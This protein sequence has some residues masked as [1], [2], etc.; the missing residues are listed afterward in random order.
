MTKGPM[1]ILRDRLGREDY[2]KLIRIDNPQL[3]Q[4]VARYVELCNPDEVFVCSDSPEDIQYIREEAIRT[5]EEKKLAVEGHTVHFDGYY[6]QARDKEN[7]RFLL[8]PSIDL[9]PHIKA[10]DKEKGLREIHTI[11]KNIMRGHRLY[12]CFFCLGPV[13]SEFTIPAVQLTDS[14]YVAHSEGLLYRP[15]YEEFRR[16]GNSARFFRFVHSQGELQGGVSKNVKQRRIYIDLENEAVYTANSQY[17][18]NTIGLKKLAL[19]L[20][21]NRASKEGWLAEHMF[22][23]GVHGPGD[24]VT[25]F[26]GAFPSLCGK[27]S[28]AML[29]NETIVGDDIAYLRIRDGEVRAVNVEKGIFGIIQGVNSQDDPILWKALH[30]PGE[31]IFS[32]VLVTEKGEVYWIDKNAETPSKGVNH[33]GQWFLG[34]R[35]AEGN[36]IPPS[37]PN[38][39]FTLELKL[40]RNVDS[41]LDNPEGVVVGGIVYGGRDSDTWVPVE[42][43]FD[44]VHGVITKGASLESETTAATLGKEGVRK[45]NPMSNLDF[46]SIPVSRYIQDYLKFGDALSNPPPIFSVNYFLRDSK[47]NFLND[48]NDKIIWLKWME[49]RSHREAKVIETPTGF[50]PK[51]QDLRVLFKNVLAKDYP[52]EAYLRQFTLRVPENLAAVERI[53]NIY[54]EKVPDTPQILF[55]ILEEQRNRLNKARERYGDYIPPNRF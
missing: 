45:F 24:R 27:T 11:L 39:R 38:A 33:S 2:R 46:L 40:L 47:G 14:A 48:K 18:G 52:E 29:Q 49:L 26:T 36:L 43:S 6:D 50:I 1:N 42:E 17:G 32:N 30:S 20:A 54:R 44:W 13:N 34:K 41:E 10:T 3:H 53:I 31:I 4:F 51:Y 9:G 25:Y 16:L 35:D 55:Q 5:G 21:I 19:R 28:T 15:G 12:V 23:M 8:P 37:H 7:T 22:L